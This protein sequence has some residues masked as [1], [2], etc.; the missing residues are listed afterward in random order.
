MQLDESIH[1]LS[2]SASSSSSSS[3]SHSISYLLAKARQM[4]ANY[5]NEEELDDMVAE[6]YLNYVAEVLQQQSPPTPQLLQLQ[7]PSLSPSRS[8]QVI[9]QL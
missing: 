4:I 6:N 3:S 9:K 1:T 5:P 8:G 7:S 2:S